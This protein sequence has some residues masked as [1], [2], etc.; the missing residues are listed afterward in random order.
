MDAVAEAADEASMAA[1]AE[2]TELGSAE[3]LA[4]AALP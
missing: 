3:L 4:A 1:A 2:L